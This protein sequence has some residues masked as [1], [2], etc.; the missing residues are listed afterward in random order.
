MASKRI[1]SI[2]IF[3]AI[4]MLMMLW[5]NDFAGMSG[6]PH[7]LK[8]AAANEDMMGFSD[9]VFPAF[10]FCVGMSIPLAIEKGIKDTNYLGGILHVL[11]RSASLVLLGVMTM[12][13]SGIEGG[14]SHA[15]FLVIMVLASFIFFNIKQPSILF[16]WSGF[17]IMIALLVYRVIM[18]API[19]TGWWGILGLIGW[20]YLF[21][22]AFYLLARKNLLLNCLAWFGFIA[23]MI[24]SSKGMLGG[25]KVPGGFTHPAIV[26]SG[27]VCT[28][29]MQKKGFAQNGII[30]GVFFLIAGIICH[31][32][33]IISKIQATPTWMFLCC[34]LYFII[35][36]LLYKLCDVKKITAWARPIQAAGTCTLT[37]YL[38]SDLWYGIVMLTGLNFGT[39]LSTG[40]LGLLRSF[41]VALFLIL[42]TELLSKINIKLRL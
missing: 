4:T 40:V 20:A 1:A 21:T 31:S 8:H 39:A 14:L 34:G 28:M 26:Y 42:I 16:R 17:F 10:L 35:A 2:D 6:V 12:N 23:L 37:C 3:R 9:L 25:F 33:W 18:G 15:W 22:S 27:I 29:L 7:W 38:L 13:M 30:L 36:A 24:L 11:F 41:V 32:F 19:K 5:V